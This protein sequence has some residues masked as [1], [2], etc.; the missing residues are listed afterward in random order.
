MRLVKDEGS[1]DA[2]IVLK[3]ILRFI[4]FVRP[5]NNGCWL[6]AGGRSKGGYGKFWYGG[7]TDIAMHFSL[8]LAGKQIP[9]GHEPDHLCENRAC[10]NPD[11]LEIVTKR[12]NLLRG[13]SPVGLNHRKKH[14][15][16]GHIF[17]EENTYLVKRNGHT[18]RHC[19]VCMRDRAKA[20]Y[21]KDPEKFRSR[22]RRYR[23]ALR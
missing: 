15:K 5:Q 21:R 7:K 16:R 10:V 18:Q 9:S 8:E 4:N 14:C 20:A 12:T 1:K 17:S 23:A 13:N 11:H 19:R 3:N 22:T 6:W 2:K